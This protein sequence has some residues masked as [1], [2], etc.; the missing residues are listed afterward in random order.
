MKHG[1]EDTVREMLRIKRSIQAVFNT[2]VRTNRCMALYSNVSC[3]C[4]QTVYGVVQ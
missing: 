1:N 4:V 3:L 2:Q